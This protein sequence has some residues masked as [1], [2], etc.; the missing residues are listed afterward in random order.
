[1][2]HVM[3]SC[4]IWHSWVLK[5]FKYCNTGITP[6][7]IITDPK[8]RILNFKRRFLNYFTSQVKSYEFLKFK[9]NY[10]SQVICSE[11]LK[12]RQAVLGGLD[13]EAE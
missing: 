10:I 5:D 1:M 3:A 6:L 11:V 12:I 2:K 9:G 7:R 8:L 13:A 4:A